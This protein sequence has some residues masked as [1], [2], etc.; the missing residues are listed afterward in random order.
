MIRREN[1]PD[2]LDGWMYSISE[3]ISSHS[4]ESLRIITET[5]HDTDTL[6]SHDFFKAHVVPFLE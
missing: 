2:S 5:F 6:V 3:L 1:V 4:H